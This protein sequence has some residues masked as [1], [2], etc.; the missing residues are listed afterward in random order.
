MTQ[1][2]MQSRTWSLVTVSALA[3]LVVGCADPSAPAVAS[4]D[5]LSLLKE[6]DGR[7]EVLNV[8]LRAVEDPNIIDDPNIR[9]SDASGHL[10]LK[11]TR[12]AD[13]SVR[14]DFKGQINNPGGETFTG[15]T[16][17]SSRGGRASAVFIAFGEV[18]GIGEVD[19]RI[20]RIDPEDA[21]VISA[22]AAARLYG[23]PDTVDDPNLIDDPNL[24]V[25]TFFTRQ[26]PA[27]AIQGT[28]VLRA[29]R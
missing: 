19:G 12:L 11:L 1:H 23:T 6:V 20:V 14:I 21:T 4:I 13:G 15:L 29:P 22:E 5:G 8:Q 26:H 10:Q 27:G 28:H 25:A 2:G 17:R 3:A 7:P 24:L 18:E 9:P 16:L